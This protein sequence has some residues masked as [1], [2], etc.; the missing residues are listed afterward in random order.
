MRNSRSQRLGKLLALPAALAVL[1]A[2]LIR[3]HFASA[4][5]LPWSFL[6]IA[7]AGTLAR[8]ALD[9]RGGRQQGRG[10]RQQVEEAALCGI[11]ALAL[12]QLAPPLQPLLYLLAAGYT[13]ALPLTLSIPLCVALL[14]L[15]A[16]LLKLP[17]QWPIWLS[18]ASFA[19]LFASLYH[20]LLGARLASAKRAELLAVRRRVSEAEERAK[21][22]RLVATAESNPERELLAGVSEVE[23]VLRGALSVAEAALHPHAVAVFLL[24]PDGES[25]RLRECLSKSDQLFRGPLPSREGALGAVLSAALPVRL[26]NATEQLSYYEGRAPHGAFLGVPLLERSGALLGALVADRETPFVEAD[27]RVLEAL[28]RELT[29]A[30]EAERLLTAVRREKEDKA[31]FFEALEAL[32]KITTAAQAAETAVLQARRMC[33]ALDLCVLTTAEGRR[34]RV[35][36]ADG[37]GTAPL[38]DLVF[39]DNAGLVSNV[40]KL[41]SALPGRELS[42]MDRVVIFDNGTVLKGLGSLKIFPLRAGGACIGT[43]VCGSRSANALPSGVQQELGTLAMQAAEALVRARLYEQAEKLATTDGLTGLTN[44]RAF[45]ELLEQRLKEAARYERP[46]SLLLLDIDHFKKVNDTHGHPAG[47]AV[48]KGVAKLAQ[49]A[50]RDTDVAARYGGEELALIL[51]ETDARGALVIAERLRKLIEAATHASEH[52]PLKVTVSIGVATTSKQA[53]AP[54]ELP[55]A[56]IEAADRALYRAKHA[57]RNRVEGA[58]R[59]AAA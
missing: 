12:I 51:P 50:A 9:E 6:G 45:N 47:D 55:S 29:R 28:A 17:A 46:L 14:G 31:R 34:H 18:H 57:G 49:K 40:V 2:L 53:K 43:L 22:L 8:F 15:D 5:P 11:I 23:E 25:V 21:E 59:Q 26:A 32:N 42:A 44:R 3:G 38:K 52:G 20:A 41:G 33:P 16:A 39:A 7:V 36:A 54:A 56:L 24:S 19:A 58:H 30:V 10:K 13:L 1:S 35:L 4:T 48:L 37:D 27:Q